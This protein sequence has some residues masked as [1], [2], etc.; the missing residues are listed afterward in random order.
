MALPL[1]QEATSKHPCLLKAEK[2]ETTRHACKHASIMGIEKTQS[3]S[4]RVK[5]QI[6]HNR[7]P[8]TKNY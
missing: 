6:V 3:V 7:S 8:E 2:F 1:E 5:V 4:F